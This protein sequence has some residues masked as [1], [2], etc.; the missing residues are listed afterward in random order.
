MTQRVPCKKCGAEILPTTAEA[1]GG[2][3]MACKNGIRKDL[4]KSKEFYRKER[5]KEAAYA[6]LRTPGLVRTEPVLHPKD[7]N[8]GIPVPLPI[9][10]RQGLGPFLLGTPRTR[11]RE[12]MAEV[13]LPLESEKPTM[14]YCCAS[15]LQF[16]YD[17]TGRVQFIGIAYDARLDVTWKGRNVFDMTAREL[18]DLINADEP[19][20][21]EYNDYDPRFPAQMVT[22][23][24]AQEQY[25]HL[26][27]ES[28]PVWA[29]VGLASE[30]FAAP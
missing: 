24:D 19:S 22:L 17:D 28:R 29:Q 4:E 6:P 2:V 13:G 8:G 14:D 26:G 20:P 16:E 23:W 12:V 7:L 5:E 30:V 3:C 10:P 27:K 1:T 9:I 15:A 11:L 21:L 25:D 18:F